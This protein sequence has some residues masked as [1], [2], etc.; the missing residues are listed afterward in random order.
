MDPLYGD[1]ALLLRVRVDALIYERHER[2]CASTAPAARKKETETETETEVS[3]SLELVPAVA[4]MS[5]C[6]PRSVDLGG[7][8]LAAGRERAGE[9]AVASLDLGTSDLA[10]LPAC[11]CLW[12]P[13]LDEVTRPAKLR[14]RKGARSKSVSSSTE[15][16]RERR[17]LTH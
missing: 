10:K 11:S 14:V 3:Q 16:M 13:I 1:V 12:S 17:L 8:E 9:E 4:T 6:S 5:R 7:G 15:R 2:L